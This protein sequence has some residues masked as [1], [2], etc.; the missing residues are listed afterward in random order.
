MIRTPSITTSTTTSTNRRRTLTSNQNATLLPTTDNTTHHSWRNIIVYLSSNIYLIAAIVYS[1]WTFLGVLFYAYYNNWTLASA[2]YYTM[3]AGLSIGFCNP[4]E[5]DRSKVFT[6]FYVLFYGSFVSGVLGLFLTSALY[7]RVLLIPPGHSI[8]AVGWRDSQDQLTFSSIIQCIW[9]HIKY[10]S[11]WYSNRSRTIITMLFIIW[12]A[13]WTAFGV[14]YQ[15][16]TF[17]TAL[18]WVITTLSTGGLQSPPCLYGTDPYDCNMGQFNGSM[19]GIFMLFGVPLY[20][21]TL[22]QFAR[23]AVQKAV[24]ARERSL[25]GKPI[26]DQDFLFAAN[27]LSPEGSTTLLLGE[28]ILLELMRLEQTDQAQIESLKK[29]F[30]ELDEQHCGEL[31]IDDLRK[32]GVVVPRKV[33]SVERKRRFRTRSVE[34]ISQITQLLGA[35]PMRSP[36]RETT[37]RSNARSSSQPIRF[38]LSSADDLFD[39][40]DFNKDVPDT[41]PPLPNDGAPS[42]LTSQVSHHHLEEAYHHL[43]DSEDGDNSS[44]NGSYKDSL[45]DSD[46]E[47]G[48]EDI[49]RFHHAH[50]NNTA[51]SQKPL[52]KNQN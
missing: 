6:I 49:S 51:N 48:K 30:F 32:A 22:S 3:D 45:L 20:A 50:S 1:I 43:K 18:Y 28:Y 12:V 52:L 17:I 14:V 38:D 29:K 5:R 4:L 19:M 47:N 33:H 2:L 42:P 11:G 34:L 31:D 21:A 46:E 27:V 13:L 23:I 15:N 36:A 24:R 10:F 25:L 35:L 26:K 37:D 40:F 39:D 44:F 9:Y 8:G 41:L 7:T 16:Y